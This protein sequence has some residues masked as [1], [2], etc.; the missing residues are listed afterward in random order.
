MNCIYGIPMESH[1]NPCDWKCLQNL[2][3]RLEEEE[4]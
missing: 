1:N 2:L 3:I 4:E